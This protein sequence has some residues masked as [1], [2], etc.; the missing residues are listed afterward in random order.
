[1]EVECPFC[2]AKNQVVEDLG[3]S[4]AYLSGECEE[5]KQVIEYNPYAENYY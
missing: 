2:H 3:D 5:C 1:M 4:P